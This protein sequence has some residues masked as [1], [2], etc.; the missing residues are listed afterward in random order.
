MI[1]PARGSAR[2]RDGSVTD[3]APES[4]RVFML[5]PIASWAPAGHAARAASEQHDAERGRRSQPVGS[6][7]GT[8]CTGSR[9]WPEITGA[10]TRCLALTS[11]EIDAIRR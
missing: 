11:S 1:P 2:Y 7:A 5:Q 3:G 9:R 8:L 10:S 4:F 6:V